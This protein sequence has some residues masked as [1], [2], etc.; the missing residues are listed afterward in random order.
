MLYLASV[1]HS[2]RQ[3]PGVDSEKFKEFVGKFSAEN[4]DKVHAKVLAAYIDHACLTRAVEKDHV[5]SFV[6]KADSLEKLTAVLKPFPADIRPVI[7]WSKTP[8]H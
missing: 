1:V 5:N 7:S 2:A 8:V 4:L 3:C 6:L